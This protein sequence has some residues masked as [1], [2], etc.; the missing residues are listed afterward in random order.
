MFAPSPVDRRV[1]HVDELS[2]LTSSSSSTSFSPEMHNQCQDIRKL[3]DADQRRPSRIGSSCAV[4]SGRDN[5]K[6]KNSSS[7][8][9]SAGS[10]MK[11]STMKRI[12]AAKNGLRLPVAAESTKKMLSSRSQTGLA[13]S[14]ASVPAEQKAPSS[15]LVRPTQSIRPTSLALSDSRGSPATRCAKSATSNCIDTCKAPVGLVQKNGTLPSR[16]VTPLTSTRLALAPATKSNKQQTTVRRQQLHQGK[17]A[18]RPL[19]SLIS[20][21]NRSVLKLIIYLAH[22]YACGRLW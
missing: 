18:W 20:C 1:Q 11:C 22:L 5:S 15:R 16:Q 10:R 6:A 2:E 7:L 4:D 13:S 19:A 9:P 17:S 3:Q 14:S 12:P 8:T 21:L